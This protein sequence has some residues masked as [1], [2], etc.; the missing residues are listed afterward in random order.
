M[1]TRTGGVPNCIPG[2]FD[3]VPGATGECRNARVANL[4]GDAFHGFEISGRSDR[5][6]G[7]DYVNS[8]RLESVRK[9][10]FLAGIHTAAGRLLA[11]AEGSIE[12]QKTVGYAIDS[13]EINLGLTA[14]LVKL[15]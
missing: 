6:A 4:V 2:D 8:K 15:I 11:I 5:E 7:L 10:Q 9:A 1:K 13:H 14:K 12:Y 3:V